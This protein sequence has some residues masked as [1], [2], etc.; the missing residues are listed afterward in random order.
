MDENKKRIRIK[1]QLK[2]KCFVVYPTLS[3]ANMFT[4]TILQQ[5]IKLEKYHVKG[6]FRQSCFFG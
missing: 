3:P 6:S 4:K 2:A 1:R 5:R